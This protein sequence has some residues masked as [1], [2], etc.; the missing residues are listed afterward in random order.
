M[1]EVLVGDVFWGFVPE[2][3]AGADTDDAVGVHLG[4]LDLVEVEE[5]GDAFFFGGFHQKVHDFAG[6]AGVEAGDRF[7][8]EDD[9]GLLDEG[10][11]DGDPLLL[12]AA[13]FVGA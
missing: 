2:D 13:E 9:F 3:F 4:E 10:S 11:G 8:G 7:V 6:S 1:L 5:E 12:A